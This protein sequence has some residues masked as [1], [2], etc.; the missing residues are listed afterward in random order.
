MYKCMKLEDGRGKVLGDSGQV[1]ATTY[2]VDRRSGHDLADHIV[3]LLEGTPLPPPEP[4]PEPIPRE[5]AEP[6][7]RG[8]PTKKT[9]APLR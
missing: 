1:L 8:E 6:S 5:K 2:V 7:G 4:E 3:S 9:A